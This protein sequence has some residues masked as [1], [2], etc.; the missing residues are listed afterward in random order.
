[1]NFLRLR[2]ISA[3][4]RCSHGGRARLAPEGA[5]RALPVTY[6]E[7]RRVQHALRL[8]GAQYARVPHAQAQRTSPRY[9][10]YGSI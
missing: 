1:M 5:R 2:K 9:A 7:Y 8:N 4:S 10:S 3:I 6:R